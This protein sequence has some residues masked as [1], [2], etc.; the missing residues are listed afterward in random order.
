[1]ETFI[2]VYCFRSRMSLG[3][4]LSGMETGSKKRSENHGPRLGNFLSGMETG[5]DVIL[6]NIYTPLETSLVEW[7]RLMHSFAQPP[8]CPWKLP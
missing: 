1:M 8:I 2:V 6:D 3:N 4:F 7:K 5:E